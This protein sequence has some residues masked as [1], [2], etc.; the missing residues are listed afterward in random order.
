[1]KPALITFGNTTTHSALSSRSRGIPLSGVPMTSCSTF[2]DFEAW[3]APSF[4]FGP[5]N[6]GSGVGVGAA[7]AV[8]FGFGFGFGFLVCELT[9]RTAPV[10]RETPSI[11]CTIDLLTI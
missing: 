6:G 4:V 2:A 7:T 11:Q 3:L 10:K 5:R 1:M 8:V 9:A